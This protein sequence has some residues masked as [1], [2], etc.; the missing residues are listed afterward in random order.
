MRKAPGPIFGRNPSGSRQEWY[1]NWKCDEMENPYLGGGGGIIN[2]TQVMRR[3]LLRHNFPILCFHNSHSGHLGLWRRNSVD[4]ALR[5]WHY[6]MLYPADFKTKW[7]CV[8][9]L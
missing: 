2:I 9:F 4:C 6:A 1:A 7:V 5:Y 3:F 8:Y